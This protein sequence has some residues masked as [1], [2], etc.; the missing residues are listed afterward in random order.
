MAVNTDL[1][2]KLRV[3]FLV[4]E[5]VQALDL[6]GPMDTL[7]SANDRFTGAPYELLT[8]G[9]TVGTVRAENGLAITPEFS[10]DDAPS[11]DTLFIPGGAGSRVVN[12]NA[13][14]LAWIASRAARTRRVVSVCTGIYIL[15][16]T[17]LLDGRRATTHWRFAEDVRRRFPKVRLDTDQL[18]L[19]DGKFHTSGGLTA[20]MDLALALVE[21]DLGKAAALAVARYLVM[22]MKRPGNQAQF[23][24]PLHAQSRGGERFGGLVDWLL[25]HLDEELGVDRLADRAAMSPRNFRRV[26]RNDVGITPA[27]YVERL[28]LEQACV[29]LTSSTESVERIA[30]RVG[31]SST[32]GFRRAFRARYGATPGQYRDRFK[33]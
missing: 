24:A 6:T 12:S 8:I 19:R 17:G 28:R 15:A 2:N 10:L 20:G 29:L 23:S 32:D 3:G 27:R 21:K 22:Y 1:T 5:G 25:E 11:L 13:A 7:G 26:F 4:Y 31:F 16:A 33:S 14:M 18:Y 30:S 9:R